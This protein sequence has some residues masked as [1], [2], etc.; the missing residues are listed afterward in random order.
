M[1]VQTGQPCGIGSNQDFAGVSTTDLGSFGCG[2][3]GQFWVLNGTPQIAGQFASGLGANANSPH[4]FV[5][6]VSPPPAGTFNLQPGVRDSIYGPGTQDWN[7]ML[8]KK[9]SINERNAFEFRAEAYD[10]INHPNWAGTGQTGGPN[11]NPTAGTF[12]EVTGKY[13]QRTMQLSLRYSF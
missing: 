9:F 7:L 12:G 2:S 6:N 5:A 13:L 4:Y 10:F 8:F 3:E 1:Q 11:F